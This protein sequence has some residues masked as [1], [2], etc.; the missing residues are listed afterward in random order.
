M[1]SLLAASLTTVLTGIPVSSFAEDIARSRYETVELDIHGGAS[2]FAKEK[3]FYSGETAPSSSKLA[4]RRRSRE[5][6]I[7]GL[8]TCSAVDAV[9]LCIVEPIPLRAP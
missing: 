7:R 9:S 5:T 2:P 3:L 4:G 6:L 8:F 1:K